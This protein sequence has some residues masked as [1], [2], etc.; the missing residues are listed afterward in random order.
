MVL[1]TSS[2]IIQVSLA[3]PRLSSLSPILNFQLKNMMT[4]FLQIL[5]STHNLFLFNF[6]KEHFAS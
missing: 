5:N 3:W 4:L 1:A 2:L 6:T